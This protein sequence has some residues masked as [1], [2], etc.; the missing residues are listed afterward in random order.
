MRSALY[1]L[2]QTFRKGVQLIQPG[3]VKE[4]GIFSNRKK[5]SEDGK[6]GWG[7]G[8]GRVWEGG[9]AGYRRVEGF[10]PKV[11]GMTGFEAVQPRLE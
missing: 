10:K 2:Q 5:A 4:L 8:R 1:A 6:Q 3:G 9:V 11:E 7:I